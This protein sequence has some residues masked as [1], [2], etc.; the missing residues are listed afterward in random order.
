MGP[1]GSYSPDALPL[2]RIAALRSAAVTE[3]VPAPPQILD[4]VLLAAPTA[5]VKPMA[6]VTAP[7]VLGAKLTG[8]P[9][10]K[11]LKYRTFELTIKRHG[12][13]ET[14]QVPLVNGP[15][16]D[17][18]AVASIV[19][20]SSGQPFMLLKTGDTRISR[21]LRQDDYVKLGSVAGRLDKVGADFTKIGLAELTEE[22]G[23]EVVND[24]LR[25]LG[26][27]LSPS[28]P[29]ESTE[30]DASFV[31]MV[32][33][34]GVAAGDGG[35]M[36][37]PGLIG[38]LFLSPAAGWQAINSGEV[39]DAGRCQMTFGRAFDA[40]G[41][42]R[43]LG[44]YVQDHPRL[45][46]R[47][48]TLGLGEPVDPR[49][50]APASEIPPPPVPSGSLE[51]Q[52]N[53]GMYTECSTV[54]VG[55]GAAM[56]DGKSVHAVAG[57]PVGTPFANQLLTLRYDRAKLLQF[58]VSEQGPLVRMPV[59][60]RPSMAVRALALS[61]ECEEPGDP[62]SWLR[63]DVLDLK[64]SRDQPVGEQLVQ[65]CPGSTPVQLGAATTASSG[66]CDMKYSYWATPAPAGV[67]H[68][69]FVPLSEALRLCRSGQGDAQT[70]AAL[71]RLADHLQ[72]IPTLGMSVENARRLLD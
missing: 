8:A 60:E 16:H 52:V 10:D 33:L 42:I 43:E 24:S 18:A 29:L 44:V 25:R 65:Q 48:D 21:T 5:G 54:P 15:G 11:F 49:R 26:Q 20:D 58:Q 62:E 47:F 63:R 35:G 28:M 70:E 3:G 41:Y 23:G 46:S 36:E 66:Q 67:D 57:T 32:R 6:Q 37:L 1:I 9:F 2:K 22:V 30:S 56:L 59:S 51:S 53:A 68:N 31:A 71:L 39:S 14:L 27:Q 17:V 4:G 34:N 72:W 40:L 13:L 55:P 64:V 12:G 61:Q 7:Q 69:E 45:R 50:Q 38:P 19:V